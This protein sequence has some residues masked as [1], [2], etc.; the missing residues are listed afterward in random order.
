L[1]EAQFRDVLREETRRHGGI[2]ALAGEPLAFELFEFL[3]AREW[4]D[5]AR[6]NQL[7][8][9]YVGFRPYFRDV[10]EP[11]RIMVFQLTIGGPVSED[12]DGPRARFE[13]MMKWTS[14]DGMDPH[15]D[16]IDGP[17]IPYDASRVILLGRLE[18]SVSVTLPLIFLIEIGQGDGA[19]GGSGVLIVGNG[20][21]GEPIAQ[22]VFVQRWRRPI[23]PGVFE[24]DE[25]KQAYPSLYGRVRDE[26]KRDP[27]S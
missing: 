21:L 18:E 25:L 23:E 20:V 7:R 22:P 10:S 17:V 15:T 5:D 4:V 9:T 3:G 6:F 14:D 26:M 8:G 19:P 13:A 11:R 12:D 1:C 27:L 24:L 2:K 16:I